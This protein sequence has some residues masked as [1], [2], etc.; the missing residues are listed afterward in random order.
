MNFVLGY[1]LAGIIALVICTVI[2]QHKATGL[3][4]KEIIKDWSHPIIF[5]L[6]WP[7]DI[8]W[9]MIMLYKH[10]KE[11]K[12]GMSEMSDKYHL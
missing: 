7:I 2:A 11:F 1:I 10:P 9:S 4:I 6:I 8:I 3:P 12:D 5:V